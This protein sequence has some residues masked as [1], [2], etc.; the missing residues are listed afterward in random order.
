MEGKLRLAAPLLALS[1]LV[2]NAPSASAAGASLSVTPAA[3]LLSGQY[4]KA[5]VQGMPPQVAGH[6]RL[7]QP[8]ATVATHHHGCTAPFS[9]LGNADSAGVATAYL[10]MHTTGDAEL[11]SEYGQWVANAGGSPV[12]LEYYDPASASVPPQSPLISSVPAGGAVRTDYTGEVGMTFDTGSQALSVGALGRYFV[13]PVT[14]VLGAG[15]S[16]AGGQLLAASTI[17]F[18][19][20]GALQVDGVQGTCAYLATTPDSF[21]GITGCTGSPADKAAVTEVAGQTDTHRLSIYASDGGPPL[22][23]CL[24]TADAG[25]TDAAGF[26]YCKVSTF[27]G[28]LDL[29]AN[30]NYIS[31]SSETTGGDG[32]LDSAG[33]SGPVLSLGSIKAPA[34]HQDEPLKCDSANPCLLVFDWQDNAGQPQVLVQQL[35]FAPSPNNCPLSQGGLML[36]SGSAEAYRAMYSWEAVTC[37]PPVSL[38]V[39]YT[40]SSSPGGIVNLNKGRTNFAVSGPLPPVSGTDPNVYA[41]IASSAVVLAYRMYTVTGSQITTLTMTPAA[42][43]RMYS[44][45]IQ[46]LNDDLETAALNPG[47]LFPPQ[48]KIFARAESS[49]ESYV[50][51]KWLAANAPNV[52][53]LPANQDPTIFPSIQSVFNVFGASN[54]GLDILDPTI[55]NNTGAIGFMD[56]STAAYFGLAT[57]KIANPSTGAVTGATSEAIARA[58]A[59]STNADGTVTFDYAKLLTDSRAYSIPMLSYLVVPRSITA[60]NAAILAPFILFA[61]N[62]SL[63]QGSG[64]LPPGYAPLSDALRAVALKIANAGPTQSSPSPSPSPSPSHSPSPSPVQSTTLPPPDLSSLPTYSPPADSGT[65]AGSGSNT[66]GAATGG[67]RIP[68]PT[69][70]PSTAVASSARTASGARTSPDTVPQYCLPIAKIYDNQGQLL[71]WVVQSG[72]ATVAAYILPAIGGLGLLAL[73]TGGGAELFGRRRRLPGAKTR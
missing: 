13:R 7:C 36:G 55:P 66:G 18:A 58:V 32:W 52:W 72:D 50:F 8:D 39:G 65:G 54:V 70:S 34:Q 15:Q 62:P 44:G 60:D 49:S 35:T 30:T 24:V 22:A 25:A 53:T 43:A 31:A 40:S 38:S 28:N 27:R 64:I 51:M 6:F 41:P 3:N 21:T 10:Q 20:Q 11:L 59:D 4:V 12:N 17:G 45:Q 57:V 46:N 29:A 47:F 5:T 69:P 26:N 1:I 9:T 42:I 23:Y 2:F 37:L 61:V 73:A 16:P 68:C 33:T 63:G 48:V 56:S 67:S 71:A 19:Q 14:S